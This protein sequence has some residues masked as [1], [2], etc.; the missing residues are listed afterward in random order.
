MKG[1]ITASLILAASAVSTPSV[2]GQ[3]QQPQQSQQQAQQEQQA[4]QGQQ[5]QKGGQKAN[6]QA[7]KSELGQKGSKVVV[8]EVIDARDVAL[9][10]TAGDGHRLVRLQNR[11]GEN[12]VVDIGL[13]SAAQDLEIN[14]G[15]RVVAVGNPARIDGR[16]VIFAMSVG[17]LT[18]VTKEQNQAAL[19]SDEWA[20]DQYGYY[21]VD[22]DW[23]AT[24]DD[25]YADWYEEE[26][27]IDWFGYDDYGDEGWFDV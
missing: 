14:Q 13:A 22:F 8:G 10:G 6:Q 9:E 24:E 5:A 7:M 4:Q 21:I 2:Y 12:V 25:W 20:T 17:K 18:D 16:P 3:S 1:L 19:Q 26:A 15:D 11:E 27:H 23:A